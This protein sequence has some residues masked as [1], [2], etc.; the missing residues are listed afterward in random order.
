MGP[1]WA[2][3]TSARGKDEEWEYEDEYGINIV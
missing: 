2:V 1:V 3:D